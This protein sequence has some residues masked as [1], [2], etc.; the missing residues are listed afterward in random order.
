MTELLKNHVSG[1]WIAGGGGGAI[2]RDPILGTELVRVSSAGLDL[3]ASY[4][5]ARRVGGAALR[6]MSYAERAA[7]LRAVIKV[8]KANR[9]RYAE[10]SIANSGSTARD[11]KADVD[12]AIFTLGSYARL[13]EQLG[14]R[15]Y[16]IDGETTALDKDGQFHGQHLMVPT[17]GIVLCINAF[18]FPAWGLWEKAGPALLSGVPVV[19]KPA[20]ATAWLTHQMVADVVGAAVLPTGALSLIC[21]SSEQLLEPLSSHDLLSFTG[22][23]QTAAMLRRHERV[24]HQS[25]R[26]NVETD[27]INSVLLDARVAVDSDFF[28]QFITDLCDEITVRAGQRCTA[29]RRIFVREEDYDTVAEALATALAKVKLGNP[30]NPTVMMGP[31]VNRSQQHHVHEG[32]ARLSKHCELLFDGAGLDWV[33]ADPRIATCVGQ[34]LLGIRKPEANSLVHE[35]EVF[36][37]VATL[38]AYQSTDQALELIR[39]G[40]GSL[41]DSIYTEDP[42]FIAQSALE[43]ADCH[44][45]VHAVTPEVSQS[46]T[47]HGNVMPGSLHGGPGRAG[48]GEE[49]GGLRALSFYHRRSALQAGTAALTHLSAA[50][51]SYRP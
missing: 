20:T 43:L 35:I 24:I 10:I 26:T 2:L 4:E 25:I 51:A 50:G 38:I 44:G 1:K 8:L 29:P 12:G 40:N 30:R 34:H 5:Y 41:V 7:C 21:G 36:G 13:G 22:A 18:N 28:S 19:C 47:G 11:I 6:A 46:R 49:L 32:L 16:L 14:D 15:R 17:R 33:D 48:G 42:A 27:S 3:D 31:V 9:E 37:P 39:R 23:A 45:R